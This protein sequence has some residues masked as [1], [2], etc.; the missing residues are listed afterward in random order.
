[1]DILIAMLA[2]WVMVSLPLA[3]FLGRCC[4]VGGEVTRND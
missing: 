4:A 1:M 3:V 2:V